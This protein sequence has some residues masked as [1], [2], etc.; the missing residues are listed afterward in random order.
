MVYL[1]LDDLMRIRDHVSVGQGARIEIMNHNQLMAALAAPRQAFFGTEAFPTLAEKAGALVYALVQGHPF[2][3]GNKRIA[4]EALLLF[5]ARNGA[6]LHAGA[7]EL[8]GF[9]REIALGRLRDGDVAQWLAD[10]IED[11][12]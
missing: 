7:D 3:D 11:Q 6:R 1:R 9:T 4:S 8:K 2:W 10:H 12:T 5:L